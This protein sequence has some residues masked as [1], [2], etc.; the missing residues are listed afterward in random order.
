MER[1]KSKLR[2]WFSVRRGTDRVY[3]YDEDVE[4]FKGSCFLNCY[5]F[6]GCVKVPRPAKYDPY[7]FSN[8]FSKSDIQNTRH[9]SQT[10]YSSSARN[11]ANI[12]TRF[13]DELNLEEITL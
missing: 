12:R 7:N 3:V 6:L 4:N 11:S 9:L 13:D 1:F 2:T 8:V 10:T 5:S